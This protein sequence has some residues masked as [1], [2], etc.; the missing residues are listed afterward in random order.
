MLEADDFGDAGFH[1]QQAI[2]KFLK[3]YLLSKG[4]GLEKT[5]DLVKFINYAIR[6]NPKFEPFVGLCEI[7]T[8]YYIEERYPFV[9]KSE[10]TKEEIEDNLEKAKVL[11]GQITDELG[12][13]GNKEEDL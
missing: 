6:Y 3:A 7:V 5:H 12:E 8:E 11:I 2:E 1:L 10:L 9:I 13:R 4:W